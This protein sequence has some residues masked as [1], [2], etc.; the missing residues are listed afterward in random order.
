MVDKK[1]ILVGGLISNLVGMR[2]HFFVVVLYGDLVLVV[3]VLRIVIAN[4]CNMLKY[5]CCSLG[6]LKKLLFVWLHKC[7]RPLCVCLG[8]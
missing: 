4:V 1:L 3:V 8:Y 6:L 2:R 5:V 7:S